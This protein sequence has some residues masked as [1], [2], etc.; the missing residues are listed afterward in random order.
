MVRHPCA[1]RVRSQKSFPFQEPAPLGA[2]VMK[3]TWLCCLLAVASFVAPVPR[4]DASFCALAGH[5]HGVVKVTPVS[6]SHGC[7]REPSCEASVEPSCAAPRTRMVKDVVYEK[8]EVTCYKTVCEKVV[9]Q[10]EIDCVRYETDKS[11]KEIEYTVCKPVWET[12]SRTVNYTVCK[13]VWE[14]CTKE[15]P[16]TV[17]KPVYET[18]EETY[19]VC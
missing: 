3:S 11:F 16:Y 17:C 9:E 5:K 8:Q 19:T 14:T 2:A 6:F 13:P 4:A 15:I 7:A 12:R 1:L 18:R 10:K